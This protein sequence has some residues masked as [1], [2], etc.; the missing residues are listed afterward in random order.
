MSADAKRVGR[1]EQFAFLGTVL[2]AGWIRDFSLAIDGGA[3]VGKWARRMGESFASVIAFEAAPEIFAELAEATRDMPNI[4]CRHAALMDRATTVSIVKPEGRK[5]KRSLYVQ[6]DESGGVHA[7]TID[8]LGLGSCGF[9]KLDIEGAE[10]LA[11]RGAR[12]TIMRH[13]PVLMIEISQY[14]NRFGNSLAITERFIG[15]LGY[16][17]VAYCQPDRVYV[18]SERLP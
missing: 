3:N 11:L 6:P 18:P 10:Y 14:G 17:P 2:T 12:K 15:R 13:R 5:A 4:T 16:L 1:E 7:V 9:I 8:S